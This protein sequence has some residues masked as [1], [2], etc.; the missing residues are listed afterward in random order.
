M[1]YVQ[2]VTLQMRKLFCKKLAACLC[3]KPPSSPSVEPPLLYT[4]N[5]GVVNGNHFSSRPLYED[6]TPSSPTTNAESVKKLLEEIRDLL[7]TQVHN[8][9]VQNYEDDK[10][11]ELKHDWMLAAAVID[12][13]C[14][15][16]FTVVFVAGSV[17]FFFKFAVHP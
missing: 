3:M 13:I 15:I 6:L 8:E 1:T 4:K 11:D 10:N 2:F 7:K 14:A 9:E 12:R 5:R 17:F 16:V